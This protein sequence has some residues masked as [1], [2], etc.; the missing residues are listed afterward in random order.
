[1]LFKASVAE[2]TSSNTTQ[3]WPLCF[4]VLKARTSRIFPN[5]EK[6][7][8]SDFLSSA[9]ISASYSFTFQIKKNLHHKKRNI[10]TRYKRS[11]MK[12]PIPIIQA[13]QVQFTLTHP[14]MGCTKIRYAKVFGKKKAETRTT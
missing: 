13:N 11:I 7:A 14:A 3:A 8:R 1:M 2:A 6:T 12:L 9:R 10:S 5:W 4:K